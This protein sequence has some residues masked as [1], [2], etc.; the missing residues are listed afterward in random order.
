MDWS[1]L[2]FHGVKEV[3]NI[4]PL[5]VHFPIALLPVAFLFFFVGIVWQKGRF[6]YAGRWVLYLSFIASGTAVLTGLLGEE[7]IPHN[8]TIHRIM[9]THE[10]IGFIILGLGFVLSLWS[11]LCRNKPLRFPRLFLLL[12]GLS[13]LAVLQNGDLGGRMVFVEGAAVKPAVPAM[14]SEHTHHHNSAEER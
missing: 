14:E 11:F 6:L 13:V 9:E 1:L 8:E 2:G 3:V 5:F 7:T 12:L 10:T 4:H